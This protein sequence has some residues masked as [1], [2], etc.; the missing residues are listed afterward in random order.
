MQKRPTL[1]KDFCFLATILGR[2]KRS[3]HYTAFCKFDP[4]HFHLL[5][6]APN[7]ARSNKRN[8]ADENLKNWNITNIVTGNGIIH[9]RRQMP[10]ANSSRDTY[11]NTTLLFDITRIFEY[12]LTRNSISRYN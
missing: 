2:V 1:M 11:V 4:V 12:L 5:R 10:L 3:Q 9:Q 6:G 8:T 7:V